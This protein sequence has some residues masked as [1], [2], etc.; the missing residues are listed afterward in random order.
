[1][2]KY[3]STPLSVAARYGHKEIAKLLIALPNVDVASKDDFGRTPLWWAQKQGH[4]RIAD[5]LLESRKYPSVDIA[6]AKIP[7]GDQAT[8]GALSP[9]SCGVCMADIFVRNYACHA[10]GSFR[11]CA[12]CRGLRAHCLVESHILSS[13]ARP[14]VWKKENVQDESDSDEQEN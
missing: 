2:S 10:C 12:Q 7:L 1:M 4:A 3:G 11:I 6:A 8:F 13:F 9:W 14:L 5:C